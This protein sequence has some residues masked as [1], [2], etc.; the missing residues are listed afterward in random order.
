MPCHGVNVKN[1]SSVLQIIL[2]VLDIL[3]EEIEE[4]KKKKKPKEVQ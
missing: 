3:L 2:S 1:N 4:A